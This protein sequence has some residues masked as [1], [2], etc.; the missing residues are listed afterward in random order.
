[1]TT[2]NAGVL[3]DANIQ[4]DKP[5]TQ[6][7]GRALRDNLLA[8][9]EGD[10]S[11]PRIALGAIA[12]GSDVDGNFVNGS[13]APT[14]PGFYDYSAFTLSAPK[15]FPAYSCIRVQGNFTLADVLTITHPTIS[16]TDRFALLGVAQGHPGTLDAATSSYAGGGGGVGAGGGTLSDC[17]GVASALAS[18]NRFWLTKRGFV[19]GLGF[20]DPL[21]P[22]VSKP[23]G[24]LLLIV[25]G[26]CDLTGGTIDASGAVS[27]GVQG[28]GGGGGGIIIIARGFIKGGT[29]NANGGNA[30]GFSGGPAGGGGGGR[31]T[32]VASSYPIGQTIA[33]AG[34]A[35]SNSGAAGDAGSFDQTTLTAARILGLLYR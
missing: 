6:G 24:G 13:S 3:A 1:M 4:A 32:T 14:A 33:V 22:S 12:F 23:G 34:G 11:A 2:Y 18:L 9:A 8:I 17:G 31:V 16:D 20:T 30:L 5:I 19:G 7:Q 25:N 26:D 35:G 29:L 27:T 10:L 28:G 21:A 15:T